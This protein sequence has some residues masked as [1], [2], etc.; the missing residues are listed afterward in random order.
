MNTATPPLSIFIVE[1]HPD[2]LIYLRFYLEEAGHRV[3]SA[4][5]MQEALHAIPEAE[6]DLLMCDIG[7]PDGDGWELLE[8]LGESHPRFAVAMS[9]FGSSSDSRRSHEVGYRKHLKKPFETAELRAVLAEAIAE[10]QQAE[11]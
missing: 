8:S 5:S 9:G 11:S 10:K 4:E 7:L 3:E 2:T 6:V 1:N